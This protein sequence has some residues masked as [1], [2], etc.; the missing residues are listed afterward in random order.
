[1]RRS[2]IL[3]VEDDLSV[4][5]ALSRLLRAS[6]F[7]THMFARPSA[8]L[9]SQIPTSDACLVLDCYLPEMTG[10]ELYAELKAAGCALPIIMITGKNDAS[11]RK[12]MEEIHPIAI[13][14]KPFDES[15]L[16]EAIA[17][18]LGSSGHGN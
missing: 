3:I 12:L 6:G 5:N 15:L 14:I 1:M 18:A 10:V 16:L 2:E 4:L 11:T 9:A 7:E 13:L 17:K 8:L